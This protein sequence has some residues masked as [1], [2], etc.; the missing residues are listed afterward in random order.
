MWLIFVL[1][2]FLF[3]MMYVL[4]VIVCLECVNGSKLLIMICSDV[5]IIECR[6][7]EG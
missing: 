1:V 6:C 7:F 3:Y 5:K 2:V 4:V